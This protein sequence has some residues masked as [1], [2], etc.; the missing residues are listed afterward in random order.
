MVDTWGDPRLHKYFPPIATAPPGVACPS[1]AT[2]AGNWSDAANW[3][4][5]VPAPGDNVVFSAPP[6]TTTGT[7]TID[8]TPVIGTF[9]KTFP[10]G[11][12]ITGVAV[13]NTA[14]N[15]TVVI[16]LPATVTG[17]SPNIAAADYTTTATLGGTGN[18]AIVGDTTI[19]AGNTLAPGDATGSSGDLRFAGNL[20]LAGGAVLEINGLSPGYSH[21]TVTLVD[22]TKTITYGGTLQLAF[23]AKLGLG[24]NT[25]TPLAATLRAGSCSAVSVTGATVRSV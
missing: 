17:S 18:D 9:T 10:V 4:G 19:L 6:I 20:T 11:A 22:A 2:I 5:G 16:S 14:T 7:I 12:V 13:G 25:L 1:P 8:V 24:E 23:R 3:T 21:D 15:S